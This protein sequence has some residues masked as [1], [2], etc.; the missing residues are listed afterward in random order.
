MRQPFNHSLLV[1]GHVT[2]VEVWHPQVIPPTQVIPHQYIGCE[3]LDD[4]Q[5]QLLPGPSGRVLGIF[6]QRQELRPE[7]TT[8]EAHLM[9]MKKRVVCGDDG[10]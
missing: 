10:M 6:G 9:W 1:H 8:G 7:V 4:P 2:T 5:Q 3:L